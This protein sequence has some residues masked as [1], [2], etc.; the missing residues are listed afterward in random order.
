MEASSFQGDQFIKKES[1]LITSPSFYAIELAIVTQP[2]T[3]DFMKLYH[4]GPSAFLELEGWLGIRAR[5]QKRPYVGCSAS[6]TW[7]FWILCY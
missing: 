1:L 7:P 5:G 2:P 3:G 6:Y 4:R